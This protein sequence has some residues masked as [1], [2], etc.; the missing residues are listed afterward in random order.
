MAGCSNP[1]SSHQLNPFASCFR[2]S[3][4]SNATSSNDHATS[5]SP[6]E[7]HPSCSS[8]T[9]P[10]FGPT[11]STTQNTNE[12]N[13]DNMRECHRF[14]PNASCFQ[15]CA[16]E[17]RTISCNEQ[18]IDNVRHRPASTITNPFLESETPGAN[19]AVPATTTTSAHT[20]RHAPPPPSIQ[21]LAEDNSNHQI[22]TTAADVGF[23]H[24]EIDLNGP[25]FGSDECF[26]TE[27]LLD[28]FEDGRASREDLFRHWSA[29]EAP[30]TPLWRK[31]GM[32]PPMTTA[33]HWALKA[34]QRKHQ[35]PQQRQVP[36]T[37]RFPSRLQDLL[38]DAPIQG[39]ASTAAGYRGDPVGTPIFIL[40][41]TLGN[42]IYTNAPGGV[43]NGPLSF[44]AACHLSFSPRGRA[45]FCPEHSCD[46]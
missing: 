22:A 37:H 7:K 38:E 26:E 40:H 14:N 39:P 28:A 10:H 6:I 2:P 4:T 32:S 41:V 31:L 29:Q 43:P 18:S 24:P 35:R 11:N 27:A 20:W 16:A 33:E 21:H 36:N 25:T 9:S 34:P 23:S 1:T 8:L 3:S 19:H 17:H 5:G 46:L 15:P 44:V 13:S 42:G 12:T 45:H 30:R